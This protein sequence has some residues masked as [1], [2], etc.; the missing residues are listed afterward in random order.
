MIRAA[1][2]AVLAVMLLLPELTQAQTIYRL[3]GPDGGITFSDKPSV[4]ADKITTVNMAAPT[5]G[6]GGATL[7]FELRQ[8]ASKYPVTLYTSS[9]C[10]PCNASRALLSGRGIPFAEKTVTN[11]GD[12]DALRRI[13][14]E[15]SLPFLTIGAQQIKGYSDS[16]WT[17]F[18]DAADYP[19]TSALPANYRNPPATPLVQV[20]KPAS[21]AQAE[22]T[23]MQPTPTEPNRQPVDTTANPAGIQF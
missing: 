4:A 2:A 9:N 11:A 3:I 23:Q 1:L 6:A 18:L 14:G 5:I 8:V 19:K 7:P 10:A 15:N 16:E 17:Q 13:S 21:A 12:I 22:E 20:Q